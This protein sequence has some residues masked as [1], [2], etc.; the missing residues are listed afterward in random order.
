MLSVNTMSTPSKKRMKNSTPFDDLM[1]TSPKA[2]HS[3][4]SPAR[5]VEG[6]A[7]VIV[8]PS[9]PS[10]ALNEIVV[11]VGEP[12]TT[13]LPAKPLSQQQVSNAP[14]SFV[15]NGGKKPIKP[16]GAS[17]MPAPPKKPKPTPLAPPIMSLNDPIPPIILN[18]S[19]VIIN[20]SSKDSLKSIQS[21]V[22]LRHSQGRG[23]GRSGVAHH[24]K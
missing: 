20:I 4:P 14:T 3:K 18:Q 9:Q 2:L 13:V 24:K 7:S 23:Q 6:S 15:A 17:G 10:S 19:K 5:T 11:A 8:Q 1:E 22:H 12:A 21:R 16:W